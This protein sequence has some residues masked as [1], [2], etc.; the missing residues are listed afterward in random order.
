MLRLLLSNID[1][2]RFER[3]IHDMYLTSLATIGRAC[4]E[5][6]MAPHCLGEL[7]ELD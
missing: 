3:R 7:S 2:K 6:T 1:E 5:H 4:D